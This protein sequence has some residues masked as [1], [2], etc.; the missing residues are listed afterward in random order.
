MFRSFCGACGSP[1]KSE[2]E[3]ASKAGMVVLKMG[4]FPLIPR[5]E[6]EGFAAHRQSWESEVEG[7]VQFETLRGGKRLGE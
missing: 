7:A 2:T 5:P 4:I 1:I 6:L 3:A